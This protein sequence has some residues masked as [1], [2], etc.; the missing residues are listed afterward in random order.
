MG[1]ETMQMI[2]NKINYLG[3]SYNVLKCKTNNEWKHFFYF[4]FISTALVI[5][6]SDSSLCF[7]FMLEFGLYLLINNV[8]IILFTIKIHKNED[9]YIIV[10]P[11][12]LVLVICNNAQCS[13]TPITIQ[14][15]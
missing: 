9:F 2:L 6:I 12:F 15:G 1:L 8:Y 4:A 7:A 3:Y 13:P 5:V 10:L 14:L 11:G